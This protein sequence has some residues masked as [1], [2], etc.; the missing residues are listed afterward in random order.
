MAGA[1]QSHFINAAERALARAY[2]EGVHSRFKSMESDG[3]GAIAAYLAPAGDTYVV[4]LTGCNCP[5]GQHH[6]ICKHLIAL[7]DMTGNLDQFIPGVY[8]ME[9]K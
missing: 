8:D 2:S 9:G 5:G 6:I 7:A 1:T 3:K 4:Q